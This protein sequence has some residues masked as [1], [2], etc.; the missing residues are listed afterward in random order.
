MV[1]E[2]TPLQTSHGDQR[3][4]TEHTPLQIERIPLQKLAAVHL[5]LQPFTARSLGTLTLLRLFR[6]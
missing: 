4:V 6:V 2:R 5:I 3:M 1:T